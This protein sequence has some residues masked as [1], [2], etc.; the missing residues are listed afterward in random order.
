MV[1]MRAAFVTLAITL[2]ATARPL[3]QA[4]RQDASAAG[5]DPQTSLTLDPAVIA[6]GFANDGQ[7][8]PSAGQVASLT[9]TNNFINFCLT[10]PD[11]PITN[12]QQIRAGSCNPAPMGVIPA[13]TAMPSSKFVFP[14]NG[15]T[16]EANTP[17][18]I[19]MAI[20]NL[21][22]GNFV[23]AQQNYFSAPQQINGQ[24]IIRGHSHVVVEQLES[25]QQTTPT[26]PNVFAFF[27]GLNG[28]AANGILSASVDRGLEPGFY[29]LSSINTASNHQPVLVPIAQHGSLDDAVYFE[30]LAPGATPDPTFAPED[31]NAGAQDP[32]AGAQDPNAGAEDPNA[33]A[34]DPNAGAED[35]NAGA[36]DPNA[37]GDTGADP[38]APDAGA[39]TGADAGA[40][41]PNAGA[42]D[43]N[44]GA[45]AGDDTGADAGA[46]APDAGA[47]TGA[48]VGQDD[49]ADAGDD[50]GADD[51][52]NVDTPDVGGVVV[53]P[54]A[55]GGN[56]NNNGGGN[57]GNNNGNN[58]N[59]PDNRF[60]N[61]R[62]NNFGF[63]NNNRFGNNRGNNRFNNGFNRGRPN[64]FRGNN[65][66]GG[67]SRGPVRNN[68]G[69]RF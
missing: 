50:T 69:R 49:G 14:T 37:G 9:S 30:V 61:N 12:G 10:V 35:P 4:K 16:I 53:A 6:T 38:N 44:A 25:F 33:G 20:N 51:G 59:K 29:K 13:T 18:T 1:S 43:P 48:D 15:A 2:A 7:A 21:E 47:D 5:G 28:A 65:G 46:D 68:G 3:I 60:G 22:T 17:F 52:A 27:K 8:Q 55:A 23:N 66:R 64:N 39:D 40:E 57:N 62:N 11:L 63:G 32:N 42:E 26:D 41:D 31:P 56:N 24:G 34:Q 19:E 45:D 54:P 36:E 58:R 67:S